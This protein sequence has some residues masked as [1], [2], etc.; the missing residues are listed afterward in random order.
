M[1]VKQAVVTGRLFDD[2]TEIL[3]GINE[4][5][6]IIVKGQNKLKNKTAI[7]IEK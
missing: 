4:G 1:A 2:K 7:I 5:D 3:E 6:E